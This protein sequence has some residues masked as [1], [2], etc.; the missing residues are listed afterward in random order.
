MGEARQSC[1]RVPANGRTGPARV[2]RERG[3]WGWANDGQKLGASG[4]TRASE[5][6]PT[7][8]RWKN[9]LARV[10]LARR[11][12]I[13]RAGFAALVGGA[14][15]PLD[16]GGGG[17][18]WAKLN[19][20]PRRVTARWASRRRTALLEAAACV[21]AQSLVRHHA[22]R[23][24][25][26]GEDGASSNLRQPKD[27]CRAPADRAIAFRADCSA[28]GDMETRAANPS[29]SCGRAGGRARLLSRSHLSIGPLMRARRERRG[30]SA[31]N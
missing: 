29:K 26:R 15:A 31:A 4:E 23:S 8:S 22:P 25:G 3:R 24:P 7:V 6:T 9:G 2:R 12:P 5:N 19:W 16:G 30:P 10:A 11:P 18:I 27:R 1:E 21:S 14:R 28:G 17:E 20:R 13:F